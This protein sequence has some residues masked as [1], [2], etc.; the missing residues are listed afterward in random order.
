MT[1]QQKNWKLA[2]SAVEKLQSMNIVVCN[3]CVAIGKPVIT[4]EPPRGV[5]FAAVPTEVAIRRGA[6]ELVRI[7]TGMFEGCAVRWLS[8]RIIDPLH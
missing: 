5:R 1:K 3:V 8:E 7:R 6:G 4:I 2:I